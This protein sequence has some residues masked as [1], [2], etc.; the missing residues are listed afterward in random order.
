MV[1]KSTIS[2][3]N[4]EEEEKDRFRDIA[5]DNYD[6]FEGEEDSIGAYGFDD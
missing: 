5:G 3:D 4:S 2:K 6:P 1:D